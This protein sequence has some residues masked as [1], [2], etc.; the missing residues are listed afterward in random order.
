MELIERLLE[1]WK[2][3]RGE[4]RHLFIGIGGGSASG[5]STIADGIRRRL[6]PLTVHTINQDRFFKPVGELPTYH[7]PSRGG[8]RPDYNRPD[9]FDLESMLACCRDVEGADVVILEGILALHYPELRELM[10][11]KCYVRADADERIIRRIK[12]NLPRSSFD[13][14]TSY[15]LESVRYQHERYNAP[16]QR[17]ADVVIPGGAADDEQR[18]AML[19]GLCAAIQR[20]FDQAT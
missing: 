20:A 10:D 15:Y 3:R 2:A 7:S 11:V 18:S 17:W 5:K 8:P 12:R 9:S 19:D 14:I 16:T 13:E 1:R 6:A 4:R